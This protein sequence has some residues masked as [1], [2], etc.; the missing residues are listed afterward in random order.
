MIDLSS[1]TA[2]VTA[3]IDA[4]PSTVWDLLA[5]LSLT[6]QLN[7]ETVSTVWAPPASSWTVGGVFR[8]TN[9]MGA[10]EW[11]VDCHVTVANPPRELGWTVL[12]PEHPSSTWWYRLAVLG[13]GRATTVHHGFRHGPNTS[14]VRMII[15]REPERADAILAG[16]RSMLV[17]NM[18]HTLE[19]VRAL[20]ET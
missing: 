9:R 6:P 1:F 13:D 14:G 20:A 7:R 19:K 18:R 12:E 16:R 2:E 11:T 17:A 10:S 4:P 3:M 8:A 15:E 5:D